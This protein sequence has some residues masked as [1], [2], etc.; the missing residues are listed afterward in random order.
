MLLSIH[1]PTRALLE[2]SVVMVMV[3]VLVL[4][5]VLHSSKMVEKRR[6]PSRTLQQPLLVPPLLLLLQW[7]P[8][9]GGDC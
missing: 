5:L 2:V 8:L 6:T 1:I 4:V 9:L 3:P 7:Q